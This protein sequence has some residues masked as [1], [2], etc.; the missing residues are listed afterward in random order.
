MVG[1]PQSTPG[2]GFFSDHQIDLVAFARRQSLADALIPDPDM[3]GSLAPHRAPGAPRGLPAPA[4]SVD[5]GFAA[6]PCQRS[7]GNGGHDCAVWIHLDL[8]SIC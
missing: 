3:A 6:R 1:G 5:A 7:V 4:E 2:A 8:D